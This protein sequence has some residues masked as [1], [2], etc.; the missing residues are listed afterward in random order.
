MKISANADREPIAI[1]GMSCRLPGANDPDSLWTMVVD[2]R[3]GVAEYP[4]GRTPE[5]DAFYRRVGM[6]DGPA[7]SRGGFLLDV[8]KFDAAF[9]EISPREAEWLD[10]QQRLL[11]EAGWEALEDAGMPAEALPR[12]KTGVFVGVWNNDYER[13]AAANSSVAEFFF[14]TG[15]LLYG[16]PS[17]I[18]FQFDLRGPDV[19]VNASCG[20]SLVAVHLAVR[21]LRSGECS[22]AF[23]G[24]VN[25]VLRHEVTQAF[26][27]AKML[28][29]DGHCKFGAARA[30]GFVRSE[31][32]GML[33]L[34]RL[35]DA[36]RD[37]DRVLAVIRGTA[38]AND[39]RGSGLL[40]MPSAAGQ[41]QA[42][43]DALADAGVDA[44]SVDYVEAHGTGTRAG[45]PIEISA[46][47]SVFGRGGD[48]A[49]P[50]R[51]GSVKSNIGHTE[52]ASGVSSIIRTVLALR[53]R[54]FPATLHVNEPNAAIDWETAGIVLEQAGSEWTGRENGPRRA[55]VNGLGLTGTNAHVILEESPQAERVITE[56]CTSWL[57]PVSA[58]AP[59]ALTDRAK[60]FAQALQESGDAAEALSDFCYTA[61]V[62]RSHLA[63]RLAVTGANA[64]ELLE[65][66]QGFVKGQQPAFV[67]AGA[68]E[69]G[70]KPKIA[71]VFPG[72]G[73][74]WPGMGRELLRTS[75]VFRRSIEETDAAIQ[76]ESGWSVLEQLEDPSLE[77]RLARIN[78][79]QPSLFAMQVALA[80]LW[81]SW[82]VIPEAVV[83]HSMGEVAAACFAGILSREDAVRIICRRGALLMRVAGAG[84]M[85]VVDLP[86]ADAE[87]LITSDL[88][89]KISVA[90]SNSPRST[91]LAGDPAALDGIVERLEK[92]DI[93]CRWVRV[94]VASHSP[95]M[96][97]LTTDLSAALAEVKP[98]AGTIPMY[99]TVGVGRTDGLQMDAAYWVTNLRKPVLFANAI[100]EMLSQGFDA[101]VELSP[102]PILVPFV[103]Q[104]SECAGRAA[105]AV[106]SLRRDEPETAAMLSALGR[107]YTAGADVDWKA[108]Y[109]AGN[110]VKLPAYP[111]QR[112][113]FWMESTRAPQAGF[114]SGS[115]H[116]LAGEPLKTATGEWIW[117][118]KLT[119]EAHPW[120]NDHA[121]G[122]AALLPASAYIELAGAAAK[123]VF[124]GGAAAVEKLQLSEVAP[125]SA[126]GFLEL[127]VVAIEETHD[128]CCLKFFVREGE[129]G[130][131]E[132]TAECLLRRAAPDEPKRAD[133]KAWEEVEFSSGTTSGAEHARRMAEL[134]YN[135]GPSFCRIDWLA[136][137]PASG[138]ARIGLPDELRREPYLLHPAA[139]DAAM[140][141]L[142]RLL[143]ERKGNMETLLP[144]SLER[145]E[146]NSIPLAGNALY[147]RATVYSDTMAGDVELF[148]DAG[149]LI[150]AIRALAF[151][152]LQP[153]ERE[154]GES[155]YEIQ[156]E[157]INAL[158]AGGQG[159]ATGKWLLIADRSGAAEELAEA[160]QFKGAAPV[161][162]ESSTLSSGA[163][164][165]AIS[166]LDAVCGVVWL[167]PLDLDCSSTLAKAQ[168]AL[169]QGANIVS[170]LA[171]IDD[172][173]DRARIW[174]ITRGTQ[175]VNG[176]A[177][178]NVLGAGAWGF[179]ASVSNEHPLSQASCLDLPEARLD[180]EADLLVDMLLENGNECRIALR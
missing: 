114:R 157:R 90:V 38:M 146:W 170:R 64:T 67:S 33:L 46:I 31:G 74:Q 127:Q 168:R 20:S 48:G 143:I 145:A 8:D 34:K 135:F 171:D 132:Q 104:T 178:N 89:E 23:A 152:P 86:R 99:S 125:L 69:D 10:P 130:A 83:G 121:V 80:E 173:S 22:L 52:S 162:V 176:E 57:L 30:D 77:G 84:A 110:L 15:G 94:D 150:V 160:L 159:T 51:I 163:G 68:V 98:S 108:V 131:W 177:V 144:V 154:V 43:L 126:E 29:P 107:L 19:S 136:L 116:P 156:W 41:K 165:D 96:D 140:Q 93:F 76:R 26:S 14:V 149:R 12:E 115:G 59:A 124:A 54:R 164:L 56:P 72:Q 180:K 66:L 32:V 175:S 134:G 42:M 24:G 5:L 60:D 17:R 85:V 100:E 147:A 120:L 103:E 148:D 75:P 45:D 151:R 88:A 40:A 166:G 117:T 53:H 123:S 102:H 37:R 139:L 161:V 172:G 39:G 153:K 82:G 65:G 35:S 78:V 141:L 122:G 58:A 28:S 128:V 7:S 174:M 79:V 133:L 18:A 179:F 11:L 138:L 47:A 167:T 4:G 101:F 113:H 81:K 25:A 36:E 91:V 63:R 92:Q 44:E 9:F 2:R 119:A 27:R 129:T 137:G 21:S 16:G 95:Q 55:S 105:L 71:F 3:E 106:G 111:W 70:K 62:R 142:G 87:R 169:A 109:P 112:E 158:T 97:P 155:L 73:S 118:A 61:S 13:H 49:D 50:C 6:P 1:I